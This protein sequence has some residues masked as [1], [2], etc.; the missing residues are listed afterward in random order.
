MMISTGLQYLFEGSRQPHVSMDHRVKPGGDEKSEQVDV[1]SIKNCES[2]R[3]LLLRN[4]KPLRRFSGS[5]SAVKYAKSEIEDG[6]R[7]NDGSVALV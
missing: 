5:P 7:P 6:V 1:G 4:F 2:F 3:G